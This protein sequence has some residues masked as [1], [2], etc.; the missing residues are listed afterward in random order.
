MDDA[1]RERLVC[2]IE[3]CA[4]VIHAATKILRIDD[5]LPAILHLEE[6]IADLRAG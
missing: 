2:L 1:K 6:E 3:E 4:E 5:R